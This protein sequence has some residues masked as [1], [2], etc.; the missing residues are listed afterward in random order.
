MPEPPP[1][2]SGRHEVNASPAISA[3]GVRT[4][5]ATRSPVGDPR[6]SRPDPFPAVRPDQAHSALPVLRIRAPRSPPPHGVGRTHAALSRVSGRSSM[7]ARRRTLQVAARPPWI[8][9][10]RV[11]KRKIAPGGEIDF[12]RPLTRWAKAWGVPGLP[13]SVSVSYSSRMRRSLGRVRP[14]VGGITLNAQ[15][16]NAPRAV[17]MEILCHEAAHVAV[18]LRHGPGAKPH[19]PEWRALV[20]KAGYAPTTSL[21]CRWVKSTAAPSTRKGRVRYRCPECKTTCFG[22]RYPSRLHCSGC[23]RDGVVALLSR[24]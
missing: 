6:G 22:S 12:S 20:R 11:L 4:E 15:L 9:R 10:V 7:G 16:A 24:D 18:F 14:R 1:P 23:L 8:F 17:V 21:S 2:N 3:E 19:G 13:T 5:P